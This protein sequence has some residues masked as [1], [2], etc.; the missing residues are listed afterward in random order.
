MK[1]YNNIKSLLCGSLLLLAGGA[2]F[3]SCTDWLDKD[4]ES[5]VAEDEA[6]KNYRNFQ[7]Y[8]EEIYNLIPLIRR[9]STTVLLG[10]SVMTLF[11]TRK[12]LHTWITRL[13]LA[14][15]VTGI[16]TPSAG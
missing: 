12:A 15:T 4:P 1:Y 13:T 14:T 11:I 2:S 8:I 9:R 6:F 10:I 5:I 16:L 7:G 3:T